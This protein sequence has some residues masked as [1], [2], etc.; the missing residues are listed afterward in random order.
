MVVSEKEKKRRER[1]REEQQAL[2]ER[3]QDE[4]NARA[5]ERAMQAPKKRTGR[6]VMARSKP[7]RK[8]IKITDDSTDDHDNDELKHLT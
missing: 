7:L 3:L 8:E 5:V 6:Q 2:Q 4:R 1:K